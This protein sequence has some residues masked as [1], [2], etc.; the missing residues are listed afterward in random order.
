MVL[1]ESSTFLPKV[2]KFLKKN[3]WFK[4]GGRH[5]SLILITVVITIV[6]PTVV[7]KR[8]MFSNTPS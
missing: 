7:A 5:P 4:I 3:A 2:L 8:P 6:C 1:G